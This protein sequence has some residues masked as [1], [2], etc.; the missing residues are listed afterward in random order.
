[1]HMAAVQ[2]WILTRAQKISLSVRQLLVINLSTAFYGLFLPGYLS[3]G[4]IRWYKISRPD[5]KSVEALAAIGY[6]RLVELGSVVL[7]G[8]VFWAGDP[9]ARTNPFIALVFVGL[10]VAL[11]AASLLLFSTTASAY[12]LRLV[13][14]LPL[15]GWADAAQ[16]K[17]TDILVTSN[18]FGVLPYSDRGY[19][20]GLSCARH[21]GGIISTFLL[22]RSLALDLSVMNV[23]W[24]RS[25]L[26]IVLMLPISLSGLGVREGS[27]ILMLQPYGVPA[28]AAVA[29]SLLILGHGLVGPV[30]GGILEARKLFAVNR[31]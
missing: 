21:L 5:N 4:A 18:S 10:L 2:M 16:C 17:L 20:L 6:N 12:V 28:P 11:A 14:R 13:G 19:V 24:V 25:A 15:T 31:R 27:L 9:M 8:L 26:Q 3:G 22:A 7:L 23:G 30:I 1:M 29:L